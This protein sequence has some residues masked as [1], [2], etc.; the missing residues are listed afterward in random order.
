MNHYPTNTEEHHP[1]FL[2]LAHD[3][4]LSRHVDEHVVELLER[5]IVSIAAEYLRHLLWYFYLFP[6]LICTNVH[7]LQTRA[8]IDEQIG[9]LGRHFIIHNLEDHANIVVGEEVNST[10]LGRYTD[11]VS[12]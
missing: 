4:R 12:G 11:Y 9:Q 6:S 2:E 10:I 5:V 7:T 8:I 3:D 1:L